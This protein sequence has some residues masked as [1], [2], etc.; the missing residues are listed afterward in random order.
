MTSLYLV[1]SSASTVTITPFFDFFGEL[2]CASEV[3]GSGRTDEQSFFFRRAF[4]HG[5]AGFRGDQ[6]GFVWHSGV[7]NFGHPCR[8][9]V[10]PSL[11]AMQG[12]LRLKGHELDVLVEFFEASSGAC[13]RSR[14]AQTGHENA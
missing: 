7:E 9:E 1:A 2:H 6:T 13:E 3:G 14:G 12:G 11:E 10:L 5:V 8:F 4:Q